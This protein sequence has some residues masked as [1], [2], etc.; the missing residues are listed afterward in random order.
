MKPI[1]TL[2]LTPGLLFSLSAQTLDIPKKERT[3]SVEVQKAIDEFNRLKSEANSKGKEK[4]NE[5]TVILPPASPLETP[6]E[7]PAPTDDADTTDAADQLLPADEAEPANEADAAAEQKPVLVTGRPP[8]DEA[9]DTEDLS[10]QAIP[11][12][13]GTTLPEPDLS[14]PMAD[15]NEPGLEIR[16]ESIR[17]GTGNLETDK[18]NLRAS[19]PAKPLGSPPSGWQME[20]TEDAPAIKRDVELQPGTV[21]S[22]D[23]KPHVLIPD[24]DGAATFAV[25]EPGFDPLEK[26]RQR[27]TV[28]AILAKSVIQLDE[29][30]KQ[31]GNALSEL[32]QILSS[33]P[34][35]EPKAI[36]VEEAEQ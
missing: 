16:V 3:V 34:S 6:E 24:A 2:L 9:A 30:A 1:Y 23:I 12:P 8:E 15:T 5:V 28:S 17:R 29:D 25:N 18:I 13:D 31:L 19:F 20:K 22:L 32:Q 27:Q 10:E 35:P 36:P 11:V 33:L 7:Q 26:Y 4:K 14:A 21:I